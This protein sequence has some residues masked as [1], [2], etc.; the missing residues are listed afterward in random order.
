MVGKNVFLAEI[1][2]YG[3]VVQWFDIFSDGEE[4]D[5]QVETLDRP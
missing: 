2:L 3:D 4:N 5:N 1:Q